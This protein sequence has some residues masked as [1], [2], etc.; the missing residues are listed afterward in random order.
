MYRKIDFKRRDR[1][2]IE[3]KVVGIEYD[4]N[5]SCH[6]ALIQY[7]DGEKRY[8]IAPRP[9]GRPDRPVLRDRGRSSP[10]SATRCPSASSPRASTCTASS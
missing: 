5:R 9:E 6:I 3:G 1:D 7:P 8:I 10:A 4:P 2:G